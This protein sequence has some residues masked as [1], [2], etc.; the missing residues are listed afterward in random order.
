MFLW[1]CHSK[2]IRANL[3]SLTTGDFE[4]VPAL[5][6]LMPLRHLTKLEH[7]DLYTTGDIESPLRS[8]MPLQYLTNLQHLDL[9]GNIC[10]T[11]APK[12]ATLAK[13]DGR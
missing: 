3:T 7:L 10:N 13:P 12:D 8:L 4:S 6:S 1:L 11:R 5:R 9:R 2:T